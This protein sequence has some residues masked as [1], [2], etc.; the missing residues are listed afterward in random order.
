MTPGTLSQTDADLFLTAFEEILSGGPTPTQLDAAPH[1]IDWHPVLRLPGMPALF[2]VCPDHPHL[3]GRGIVTSWL[4]HLDPASGLA[5][6]RSR[7]YRL[8][9]PLEADARMLHRQAARLGALPLIMD[10]L[11]GLLR[12]FPAELRELIGGLEDGAVDARLD[13]IVAAWPAA[14]ATSRGRGALH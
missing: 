2:G 10:D 1:L 12:D 13:A 14:I 8:G 9:L 5:R 3:S 4:L 6:T 11:Y 7:W